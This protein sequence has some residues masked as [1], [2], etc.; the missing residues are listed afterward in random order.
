MKG[1]V[2]DI[3]KF[4]IHDGPGIRTTVFLKG[5]MMHCLWCHNP[6]SLSPKI[7]LSYDKGSCTNC[8]ACKVCPHGVHTHEHREHRVTFADCVACGDC[9]SNCPTQALTLIGKEMTPKEVIA[10]VVKDKRYYDSSGGGVTFSGG[11]ATLQFDFLLELLKEA[12][13]EGISTALETNGVIEIN[14]LQ[15]LIP[16]VDIFLFDYKVTNPEKH[17][18]Y[19]GQSQDRVLASLDLLAQE[20]AE[21]ILR[22]PIIPGYNDNQQHFTAIRALKNRYPN[23]TKVEVMA[24]HDSGRYNWENLGLPYTLMDVKNV[25]QEQKRLWEAAIQ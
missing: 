1:I 17:L 5:C 24:Y 22:C 14:R 7:Q 18:Q 13:Q 9:V 8:G 11:E 3:Q 2:F 16:L 21:T 15:K 12:R 23:I 20:E 19:T 10:E 25:S 4:S 6:E